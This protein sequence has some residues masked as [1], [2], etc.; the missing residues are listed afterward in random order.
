M[1]GGGLNPNLAVMAVIVTM[2]C[3]ADRRAPDM[4]KSQSPNWALPEPDRISRS[5]AGK[6]LLFR[7]GQT[8]AS[9]PPRCGHSAWNG[10][11]LTCPGTENGDLFSEGGETSPSPGGMAPSEPTGKFGYFRCHEITL[12]SDAN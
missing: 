11:Y 6:S 5:A 3:S 8:V 9:G 12:N 2:M 7:P 4:L 10:K 1:H